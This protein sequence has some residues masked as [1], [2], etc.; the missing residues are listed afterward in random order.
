MSA[1]ALCSLDEATSFIAEVI[2]SVLLTEPILS[3]ISFSADTA[4]RFYAFPASMLQMEAASVLITLSA[5]SLTFPS[6][7]AS[8]TS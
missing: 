2:F 6:P 3:F 4:S 1:S 5:S 7:R 8:S